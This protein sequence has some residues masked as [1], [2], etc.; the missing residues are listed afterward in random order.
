MNN[1]DNTART[2]VGRTLKK[3][4]G[5]DTT[6]LVDEIDAKRKEQVLLGIAKRKSLP[7]SIADRIAG[8]TFHY[9]NWY[10]PGGREEFE[11]NE[12]LRYVDKMYPFAEG[13]QLLVDEPTH[14]FQIEACELK[15]KFL[16]EKGFRYI[17]VRPQ[18]TLAQVIEEFLA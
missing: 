15:G 18:M 1:S 14:Q 6:I 5:A 8:S 3:K 4:G 12:K 13:G 2:P 10:Y 7:H 16:K 17:I 11:Q 9:R